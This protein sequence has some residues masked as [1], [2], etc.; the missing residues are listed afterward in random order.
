MATTKRSYSPTIDDI[1]QYNIKRQRLL[2]DLDSLS[3]SSDSQQSS[4]S[5]TPRAQS[6]KNTEYIPDIEEFLINN[7]DDQDV[8]ESSKHL[9]D[10]NTD[11]VDNW[12]I[13]NSVTKIPELNS[14][15][16]KFSLDR[17]QS[18][19]KFALRYNKFNNR[20]LH[21]NGADIDITNDQI[22]YDYE[23]L[24]YWSLIKFIPNPW[25]VIYKN[26]EIWY[27]NV[28]KL[29]EL[30]NQLL[31]NNNRIEMLPDDYEGRVDI[32]ND[33]NLMNDDNDFMIDEVDMEENEGLKD[34]DVDDDNDTIKGGN[35]NG[36]RNIPSLENISHNN[37]G[38]YY[39][40]SSFDTSQT[41][42]DDGNDNDAMD[43]D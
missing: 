34:D 9:L 31:E 43:I 16:V 20:G 27:F 25:W 17:L 30:N 40:N 35:W 13:P 33:E 15:D 8:L 21:S 2:N 1:R 38:S 29:N 24:R 23:T 6:S 36:N 19:K 39:G 42:I 41:E 18:R 28:H 12:I 4:Q 5:S 37:Y 11:D 22:L 14:R 10:L 26:W 3:L 32:T 7:Q